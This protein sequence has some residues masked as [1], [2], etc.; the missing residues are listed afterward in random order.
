MPT[1]LEYV[2]VPRL[3]PRVLPHEQI[4][5]LLDSIDTTSTAG[6]RDRSMLELLYSSGQRASELL[7]LNVKHVELK[8]GTAFVKGKGRKERLVPVGATA[9]RYLES[10]LRAVRPWLVR[11]ATSALFL[12]DEGKR[13]PYHTL[14]RIV[15]RIAKN[16]E[17]DGKVTAHVFRRSCTSE[18]VKGDANLYHVSRL[19]GHESLE[20]LKHYVKLDITDIRKTHQK[21]HPRERDEKRR[22]EPDSR[23]DNGRQDDQS[24]A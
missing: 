24:I 23:G 3:L 22:G 21:T 7:D 15:L 1:K 19:L 10:Y 8:A 17:L 11:S 12:D 9:R 2:K 16:A 13:M 4:R 14:R 18:L 20:T 6:F 5:A